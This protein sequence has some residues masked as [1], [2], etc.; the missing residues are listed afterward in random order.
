MP[1]WENPME[2]LI[3]AAQKLKGRKSDSSNV[4]PTKIAEFNRVLHPFVLA[5]AEAAGISP[6]HI[7]M[8]AVFLM[9]GGG[10]LPCHLGPPLTEEE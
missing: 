2:D 8:H 6:H 7:V 4:T 3:E 5:A 1:E 9:P 10:L